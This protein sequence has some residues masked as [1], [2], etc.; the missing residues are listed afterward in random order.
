MM[1]GSNVEDVWSHAIFS[2]WGELNVGQTQYIATK[3][4][5]TLAVVVAEVVVGGRGI[6]M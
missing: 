1:A 3:Q 5:V 2:W 4:H 6:F